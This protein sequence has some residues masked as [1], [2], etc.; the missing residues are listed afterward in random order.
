MNKERGVRQEIE[1]TAAAK[2][3]LVVSVPAMRNVEISGEK[4]VNAQ[5]IMG[6]A[7]LTGKNFSIRQF[8][9]ILEVSCHVRLHCCGKDWPIRHLH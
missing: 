1:Y 3:Y 4:E 6:R 5:S 9:R 8:L 7:D 2:V